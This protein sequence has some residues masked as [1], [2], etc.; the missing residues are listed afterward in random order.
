[1]VLGDSDE[2]IGQCMLLKVVDG[3]LGEIGWYF[4]RGFW[5]QGYA[6]EAAEAIIAYSRD[7]LGVK[8]LCAQIDERNERSKRLAER[9]GFTLNAHLP[10]ADFGGRV[11]D[12][13]YY[14]MQFA[15]T[16]KRD[17][18]SSMPPAVYPMREGAAGGIIL[19]IALSSAMM[20]IIL[21]GS[22]GGLA[23]EADKLAAEKAWNALLGN[24]GLAMGQ[25]VD[26]FV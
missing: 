24:R 22:I 25:G 14:S 8:R 4:R 6:R 23:D 26:A 7:T 21:D 1:M 5:G 12:V 11:A 13:A 19:S 17:N 18:Q 20:A 16:E 15:L 3:Y 9:L 10:E 2:Y